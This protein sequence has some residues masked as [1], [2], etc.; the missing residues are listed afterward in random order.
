MDGCWG[1][2]AVTSFWE[3]FAKELNHGR[4]L[5]DAAAAAGVGFYIYSGL[6]SC[7]KI[8]DGK[9]DVPHFDIKAEVEEHIRARRLNA[10]FT[11]VAF[12][13][14]NFIGFGMLPKQADGSLGFGFPQGETPLAMVAVADTGGVV[15]P[16]FEQPEQFAGRT[17]GV[18]GDDR[19][20][21]EYAAVMTRVLGVPVKYQHIPRETYAGFGFP[22]A[23]ELANMFEFNRYY[24]PERKADLAQSR[25]LY[26]Q[27]R[28]LE[29]WL[30]QNKGQ[31]DALIGR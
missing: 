16:M 13:Y 12:Y 6:P 11:H 24:I 29:Q 2:F 17:V 25:K 28:T 20:C 21:D 14:E 19:P 15:R 18:V 8:S 22:G 5:A 26:P 30:E 1:V 27:M 9:Y 3:H 31:F 10:A 7:R 23:E 4:N